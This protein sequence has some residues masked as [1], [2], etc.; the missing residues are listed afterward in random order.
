MA[1]LLPSDI[2]TQ[3]NKD[4]SS[5]GQALAAVILPAVQKWA[6]KRCGY[7]FEVAARTEYYSDG[8]NWFPLHTFAPITVAPT[9]TSYNTT[10]EAHEAVTQT[11]RLLN[12][13][14]AFIQNFDALPYPDGIAITYTSG[15]TSGTFPTDL[16]QALIELAAQKMIDSETP[17]QKLKSL[18]SGQY[19]EEYDS[20]TTSQVPAN[21][22][23]VVD[24]YRLS[25]AI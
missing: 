4:L 23:E 13:G 8:G 7:S 21:I 22:L 1:L 18:T 9:A 15:W 20:I 19:K 24:R 17:G 6:E 3:L 2:E 11:V 25:V 12:A 5:N 14:A 10:T 16:K